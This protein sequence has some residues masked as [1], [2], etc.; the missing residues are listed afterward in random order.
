MTGD[1]T[2]HTPL[3]RRAALAALTLAM[4][5]PLP[6]H[7]EM[8]AT[9]DRPVT[10]S[11]YNY[12]LASANAGADATRE[13]LAGFKAKFPN[14]TVETVA[15]PSNEI[16]TRVQADI[17]AG[18]QPDVAQLVF[19]DLIYI[20]SDL[21]ANALEEMVRP[22]ELKAHL[23]GMFPRGL[24]LGKIDGK[25][26]GLA[27]TFSTPILYYNADLFR[28]AG[29]DPDQPPKTWAEVAA[30]GKAIR[31]KTGKNGFFPGAYGPAD[32]TFVYQSIVMSNGGK[33]R[34]GN[35]LTFAD[36]KA[37]AAVKMLRDMV[38]SGAHARIDLASASDTMAAGNLGMF[39]YT[40]ALHAS[41]KKAATGKF[42]LRVAAMPA[43][44]DLPTAPTNSGS[45]LYVFSKDPLKQRAAYELLKHLTSKEAYTVITAKIGYLPLRLDIVEDPAYLAGWVKDNPAI[46]PNLEQLQRLTPNIAFPG[47]NYRQVEKMMMDALRDAVFGAGDP[48]TV[49][50]AA[51]SEA[52]GLMP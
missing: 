8:A 33:V 11:F 29:L 17:V 9:I 21:G 51:Q 39:L 19:R 2:M 7:A 49:L 20:A 13:L 45:A 28:A 14:V 35:K 36:A 12:N 22:D 34:E 44:G 23:S 3:S 46:R 43:F 24:D 25:T 10:I 40:S 26:Y 42:D 38:D 32:G 52:Q 30:A 1:P 5:A 47:P 4:A 37:G 27:Y 16:L 41:L 18:R 31:D 48:V 50:K 6:V 15:V